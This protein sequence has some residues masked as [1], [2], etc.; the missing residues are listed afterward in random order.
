[1]IN[2]RQF[3]QAS[4]AW[5]SLQAMGQASAQTASNYKA[6]VCVFLAG[7][8]DTFNTVLA[9]DD[10]SWAAYESVRSLGT[11]PIALKKVGT[12]PVATAPNG[13]P[14]R[15]GGVLALSP[16][17]ALAGGRALALH[18][19]LTR[20]QDLFNTQRRLAVIANVGPLIQPV[21]KAQVV[22]IAQGRAGSSQG[23]SLPPKLYSHNDQQ[24]AWQSMGAE[25][26]TQGWGGRL[27]DAYV[28]PGTQPGYYGAISVAG[29][30]VWLAGQ[31]VRP[32]QLSPG[33]PVVMGNYN[34]TNGTS[35][36]YG[37]GPLVDAIRRIASNG[38]AGTGAAG[39]PRMGHVLMADMGTVS[40][41]SIQAEA[42]LT[43]AFKDNPV[44]AAPLGPASRLQYSGTT[45]NGL[46]TQL[47][48]V[49]RVIAARSSLGAGRQV[50]FVQMGGFDT[51]DNQNVQHADLMARLDHA[52][53]YFDET[54]GNLEAA[55]HT[56][57]RSMVTAFTASDF[58]RTFTSNGDGTDHGWGAHHFVLGGAVRGGQVYGRVPKLAPKNANN[59]S[60]DGSDDQLGNGVLLPT[61]S[62]EQLGATLAKWFEVP[63]PGQVFTNL[64]RFASS[65]LGFMG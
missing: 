58:G 52:L 12:A 15:L 41:R 34:A 55:G 39:K 28:P 18:P 36:I 8:N 50:F 38:M 31:R 51:H 65:D 35:S 19:N 11:S 59:N 4:A 53:G 20:L 23:V 45:V 7:G 25:G 14:E 56:G 5:A 26:A 22:A 6:I 57:L 48:A 61:T 27:V 49:A 63:Q 10:E 21:T 46:A 62:V 1:M 17:T 43:K 54:L 24:S 42:L 44:T 32:Y 13:S 60:F 16:V 47:Q 9:T 33:G 40:E 37:S 30:S 3:L 2:R 64:G 29:S